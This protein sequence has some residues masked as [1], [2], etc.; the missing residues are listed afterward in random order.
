VNAYLV[1]FL[2]AA[3]TTFVTT[4]LVRWA[5]VREGAIVQPADRRVHTTPTPTLGGLAMYLGFVAA[6]GTSFALPFFTDVHAGSPEPVGGLAACTL[7]VVL[8]AV[9]DAKDITPLTKLTGQIFVGGLLVLFG[10]QLDFFVLPF[11][12]GGFQVVALGGDLA[13]P[14]SVLWVV[15]LANAV[16]L[17]DGLDGL[18][19]GMVAIASGAF[20]LFIVRAPSAF[21]DASE[22]A[23]FAAIAGGICVGFLP[24]NF[25]PAKIFMGDSGSMF[26]GMLLAIATISGIGRNPYPPTPG[27]LAVSAVPLL[28]PLL[29]LLVPFLDVA[30]AIVRRTRRG[31]SIGTADKEHLHHRILDIGHSHRQAVLLMY[32]WSALI[33]GSALAVGLIDGRLTVG[34][35][36]AGAV[37]LF[38]ATALPRLAQRRRNGNGRRNGRATTDAAESGAPEHTARPI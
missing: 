5:A 12:G 2:V 19:A 7:M 13:V 15:A 23:L 3:T 29:V 16:N 25:H 18:A 20:F 8:G 34:L 4:P 30:L 32:L 28:V 17:I 31:H 24:W 14:L 9:D 21:G 33:S 6:L 36:V 11:G 27:D 10:V 37:V 26:L 1:V 22:A 38:L 35:I